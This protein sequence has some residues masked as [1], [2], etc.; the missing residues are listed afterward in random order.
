MW[1]NLLELLTLCSFTVWIFTFFR[2]RNDTLLLKS[3]VLRSV[4]PGIFVPKILKYFSTI[5]A[6]NKI[7]LISRYFWILE[8]FFYLATLQ[9]EYSVT[10]HDFSFSDFQETQKYWNSIMCRSGTWNFTHTWQHL[11]E[12]RIAVHSRP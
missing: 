5:L 4:R 6:D 11:R 7:F 9:T 8:T 10:C 3:Y 1:D 12:A 2:I